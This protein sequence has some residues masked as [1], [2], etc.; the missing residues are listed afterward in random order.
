MRQNNKHSIL[1]LK[2]RSSLA[3]RTFMGATKKRLLLSKSSSTMIKGITTIRISSTKIKM[4]STTRHS[5]RIRTTISNQVSMLIQIKATT[6]PKDTINNITIIKM[7]R[8]INSP[9]RTPSTRLQK[10]NSTTPTSCKEGLESRR[11]SL[12]ITHLH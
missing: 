10:K 7:V 2:M 1:W 5:R 3:L 12:I 8:P 4:L 11:E 9:C 6:T